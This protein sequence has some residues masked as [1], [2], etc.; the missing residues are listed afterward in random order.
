MKYYKTFDIIFFSWTIVKVC[1]ITVSV[2]HAIL[3][4]VLCSYILIAE[5]S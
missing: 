2:I 1:L 5:Q 3:N 4:S